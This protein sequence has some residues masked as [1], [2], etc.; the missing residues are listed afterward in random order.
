MLLCLDRW[1]IAYLFLLAIDFVDA[2]LAMAI[3]QLTGRRVTL[4]RT[5]FL[6]A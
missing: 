1:G 5:Y 6:A 3:D 2:V 4:R